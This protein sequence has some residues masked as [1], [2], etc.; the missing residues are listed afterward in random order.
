[1]LGPNDALKTVPGKDPIEKIA[2]K[3]DAWLFP[4][5]QTIKNL[6]IKLARFKKN[7]D[8]KKLVLMYATKFE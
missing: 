4:E 6:Q 1:M 7:P 5:S 3:I 8:K 2:M